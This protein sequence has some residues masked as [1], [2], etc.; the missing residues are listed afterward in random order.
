M[1][2]TALESSKTEPQTSVEELR[3]LAED[4]ILDGEL[5]QLSTKTLSERRLIFQK[6]FW[7][8][9]RE[10]CQAVGT[11]ELKA[12]FRH[13]SQGHT[14]PGGRFGNPALTKPL[15]PVSLKGWYTVLAAWFR[16]LQAEGYVETNPMARIPKPAVR[17]E[18]KPPLTDEHAGRLIEAARRSNNPER[19][20]VIVLLLLDSGLRASEL[21]GLKVADIDLQGRAFKVTGKGNKLRHGYL[22]RLTTRTLLRY[23]RHEKRRPNDYLFEAE[24]GCCGGTGSPLTASGLRQLV[25]R[26]ARRGGI[27]SQCSPH[28][29]R[30]TFCV[31][32]LRNGGN[33]FAAQG[34]MGHSTLDMTRKYCR[35]A[36]TDLERQ[37]RA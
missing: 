18:I 17:E 23:L 27:E 16:W 4:W 1:V 20:M 2:K 35:L 28:T 5:Q 12:F 10:G 13:L 9:D 24:R 6:L 34:L 8:I 11:R 33:V 7:F 32:F 14:E 3:A 21:V 19:D 36:E 37:H 15:R 29:L 22:G 30:Q 25:E 31:N 26:L